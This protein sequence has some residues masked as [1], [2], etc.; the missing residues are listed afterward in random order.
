MLKQLPIVAAN[1]ST[2]CGT[3]PSKAQPLNA[4]ATSLEEEFRAIVRRAAAESAE[5]VSLTDDT[6]KALNLAFDSPVP[7]VAEL[8]HEVIRGSH[9][10]VGV[11]EGAAA[12]AD[13][14][15]HRLISDLVAGETP[16]DLADVVGWEEV[17]RT[18]SLLASSGLLRGLS[19][20][21]DRKPV[22]VSRFA[23]LHLTR[24]CQLE[25]AH[26]YADSSPSVDRSNELSTER[27][28]RFIDEFAAQGGKRVLF[29]GGE[30]LMHDGCLELMAA[31]R[32]HGLHVTL[33][34]NGLLVK[35]VASQLHSLVDEMQ[36]SIDGP[37]AESHDA[38]RGRNS[39]KHAVAAVDAL[40]AQGT[41]TRIGMTMVP[42][43]WKTWVEKLDLLRNRWAWSPH[44]TFNLTYGV[45][46]HGRGAHIDPTEQVSPAEARAFVAEVNQVS[47]QITRYMTGCGYADQLV[48]GPDGTV[49]PCHLL[50]GR[51]CHVDDMPLGDIVALVKGV[52]KQVDVDHVDGCSTCEIRYL[53]GGTCRVRDSKNT[54]SRLVTTCTAEKKHDFYVK[55][56]DSFEQQ[57]R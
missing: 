9:V 25:C 42:S 3:C 14:A 31:A 29:T 39:F 18:L 52:A 10:W 38:I 37:D 41:P 27:W 40:A 47:P 15:Q 22:G 57:V 1:G 24:A 20:Y 28:R 34:S 6:A 49:Y 48:L 5:Q 7:L 23:R 55:L 12:V 35:K 56:V 50:D 11:R 8:H 30:A 54:G 19:G 33:F 46:A 51:I 45:M 43:T 44:V 53:C 17:S 4:A 13:D 16:H 26:C 36:I 21:R 2:G 32:G